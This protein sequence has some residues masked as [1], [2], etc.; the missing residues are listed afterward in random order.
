MLQVLAAQVAVAIQNARLY[1]DARSR[2]RQLAAILDVN[3][4]LALGPELEEILARITEEA[5]HLL[6]A[7]AAALRLLEGDQLVRVARFGFQGPARSAERVPLAESPGSDLIVREKRPII[8][9]DFPNDPRF[10]PALREGARAH[11]FTSWLGVPLRGRE[12]VLGVLTVLGGEERRF[13][14]SDVS[15]LEA[16]ADQAALA[17]E[18]ARLL[19]TAERRAAEAT[20]VGEVGRAITRS[21]ASRR[22]S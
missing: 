21:L 19:A 15:L 6:G 7:K 5:A 3:K 22:S 13:A 17:A 8:S 11:G 2:A 10:D 14:E 9:D 12:Q 18:N 4:R 1:Q 16:F 20:A